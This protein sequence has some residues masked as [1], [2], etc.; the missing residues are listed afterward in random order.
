MYKRAY[1][2][3][4]NLKICS[5]KHVQKCR[6]HINANRKLNG[7]FKKSC[8]QDGA[9]VKKAQQK[10]TNKVIVDSQIVVERREIVENDRKIHRNVYGEYMC[11]TQKMYERTQ[12][13]ATYIVRNIEDVKWTQKKQKLLWKAH[14]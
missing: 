14:G 2:T 10:K 13:I 4:V 8:K 12:K 5:R 3:Q 9:K 6:Q 11:I 1:K 7:N